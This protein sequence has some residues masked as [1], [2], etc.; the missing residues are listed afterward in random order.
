VQIYRETI[1]PLYAYVS[2]RVGGDIG[3]A[4]DLVQQTW[5]RALDVWPVGGM[6]D[7]P[8]AWLQRVA[9]NAL[10]SHFRRVRPEPTDPVLLDLES[11]T[12]L[13]SQPDVAA[14]VNWGLARLRRSH[15]QVLAAFYFDGKSV[16]EIAEDQRTSERAV[17]GR[18]RRARAKLR[19]K[20][21][22]IVK[23]AA[24]LRD[25]AIRERT[26]HAR[27]TPTP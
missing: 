7:A 4:E 13:P 18:L 26:D 1:R 6:P 27:Q 14:L 19:K 12:D 5:L 8:L 20:L 3:L 17:E 22:R 2:R 25:S 11:S 9:H 23:P 21:E 10:V 24:E 15:A 16:R